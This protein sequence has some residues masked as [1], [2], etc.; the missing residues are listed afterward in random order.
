MYRFRCDQV[1][2]PEFLTKLIRHF[3]DEYVPRFLR[4]QNYYEVKTEILDR[5]MTDNKPNNRLAHGFARYITN[6]ATSY[7]IGKPV[8]YQT[9]EKTYQDALNDIFKGNH[10]NNLNFEVSKEASKKGIGYLLLF[11]NEAGRLR[12]KK[13]SAEDIIPV[14]SPSLDEFLEAAVRIWSE[15]DIDGNLLYEYADVYDAAYIHHY[16]HPA[17]TELYEAYAPDGGTAIEAHYLGD[18]PVIVV[19]NN[20]DRIGDYETVISLMNGYDKAQSDTGNDMEYF[21]DAYL[22]ITGASDVVENA[23]SGEGED[24]DSRRALSDFRRNKILFLDEKGQAEWLTKNVNDA[25]T[26][27]YKDRL[28]RDIFLL[29]QVPALTDESF[30]GNL[31][32]IAIKYK[33][34][35][36]EQLSIM[37]EN[38]FRSAQTKMLQIV[39]GYLNTR[40]NKDWDPD[41][42][43][44]KYERNF[45]EN[46]SDLIEDV[47]NMDGIVS[48]QTQLDYLP[49]SIVKDA[50]AEI[51]KIQKE[52]AANEG[53][54]RVAQE[55]TW[56]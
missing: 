41:S 13:A 5:T 19:W 43:E 29:S 39:T 44:Q 33:L 22:A 47:K 56:Q 21:T 55:A 6:M 11:I 3:K 9:G 35:G 2:E 45:T 32:G 36:L 42:V 12:I 48:R 50:A 23:L 4:A 49:A 27:H 26:E 37:K 25:A 20:E 53:L 24:E 7:F 18:I 54:P 14:Y 52:A 10:I 1:I 38:K 51:E 28:Y 31:T 30:S 17:G 40:M 16:R 15:S 46:I 34:I 8:R